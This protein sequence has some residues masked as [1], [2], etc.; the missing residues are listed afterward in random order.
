[1]RVLCHIEGFSRL[2]ACF[3]LARRARGQ[4]DLVVGAAGQDVGQ[5]A[6]AGPA[7]QLFPGVDLVGGE[8]PGADAEVGGVLEEVAGELRLGPE[9]DVLGDPG[10]LAA[11]LVGG[12]VFR[13]V[14]RSPD[15]GV[16]GR[17]GEG[18]GDEDLAQGRAADGAAVLPGGAGAVG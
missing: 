3:T 10:V 15:E 6:G 8:E 4:G 14:E 16:A 17:G 2:A 18:E 7:A 1:M 13:Q 9:R 11:F 12:P 5:A